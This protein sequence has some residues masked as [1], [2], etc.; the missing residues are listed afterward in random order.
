MDYEIREIQTE[1]EL[2]QAL[3][4]RIEVFVKEQGIPLY[5][6]KDGKDPESKHVVAQ[7]QHGEFAACGRLSPSGQPELGIISRISVLKVH[8]GKGLGK[9]IVKELEKI[10]LKNAYKRVQLKPHIYLKPFYEKMDYREITQDQESVGKHAL[11]L[12]EKIL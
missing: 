2:K 10:A 11:I 3:E 7:T 12:M 6:E 9:E 5:L 8:R 4:I 1:A